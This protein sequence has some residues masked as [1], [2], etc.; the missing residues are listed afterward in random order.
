MA[1]PE[2]RAKGKVTVGV[3]HGSDPDIVKNLLVEIALEISEVLRE[4][5]PEA[6]FVSF[7]ES[8]LSMALFFW[9]DDYKRLFPVTDLI[10]TRICTRFRECGIDIPFPTRTLLLEKEGQWHTELK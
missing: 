2:P 7:G 1:F 6:Y 8:A 4:P 10:N 3:A 9:V 5:L